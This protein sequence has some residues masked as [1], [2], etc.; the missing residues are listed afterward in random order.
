MITFDGPRLCH[1]LILQLLEM[2][3]TK[4]IIVAHQY[5]SFIASSKQIFNSI[6]MPSLAQRRQ[7]RV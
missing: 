3:R 6:Q 5:G 2:E 7:H 1:P 4:Q